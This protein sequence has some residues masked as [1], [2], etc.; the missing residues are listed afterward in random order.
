MQPQEPHSIYNDA[1]VPVTCKLEVKTLLQ[2]NVR[3]CGKYEEL[4]LSKHERIQFRRKLFAC[5]VTR[6]EQ[7]H[8]ELPLSYDTN[9][10][11][12]S[13]FKLVIAEN[14]QKRGSS[15]RGYT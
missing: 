7:C 11:L 14:Y 3:T 5:L 9:I 12:N 13:L 6:T 15:K 10:F 4:A 2:A 8:V 1:V